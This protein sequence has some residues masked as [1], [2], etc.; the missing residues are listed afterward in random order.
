MPFSE[1]DVQEWQGLDYF[2]QIEHT[3]L[4]VFFQLVQHANDDTGMEA[5]DQ[6]VQAFIDLVDASP[7]WNVTAATKYAKSVQTIT[8]TP[9]E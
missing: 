7:D 3:S 4:P 2:V 6:G 5:R 9:P 1:P 8:P